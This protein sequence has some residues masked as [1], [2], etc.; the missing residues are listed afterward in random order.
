MSDE[1]ESVLL[2]A[3]DKKFT[4]VIVIG[5]RKSGEVHCLHSLDELETVKLL[6]ITAAQHR[7]LL[8]EALVDQ[9]T[10]TRN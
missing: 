4:E 5:V 10:V 3:S 7:I 9:F 1:V 8:L 2:E 6:E